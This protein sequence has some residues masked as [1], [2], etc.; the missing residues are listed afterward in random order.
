MKLHKFLFKFIGKN[1]LYSIIFCF[2]FLI[3]L[4]S[5]K[6]FNTLYSIIKND[7]DIRLSKSYSKIYFSGYC[8]KQSHGYIIYIKNK[9]DD[10]INNDQ[11][12]KIINFENRNIPYWLFESAGKKINDNHIILVNYKKDN[13]NKFDF[14]NFNILDSFEDK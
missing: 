6:V 14:S 7:H 11:I 5:N 12:P 8:K 4:H 10:K 2:L 1:L 9:F 3:F 13:S